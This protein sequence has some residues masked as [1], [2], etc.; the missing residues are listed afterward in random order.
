MSTLLIFSA[1]GL[2]FLAFSIRHHLHCET[3]KGNDVLWFT[4]W[5]RLCKTEKPNYVQRF[6]AVMALSVRRDS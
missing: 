6:D 1:I 4:L 5:D 3:A 2:V